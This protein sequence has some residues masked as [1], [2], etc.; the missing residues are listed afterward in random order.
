MKAPAQVIPVMAIGALL[1]LCWRGAQK[2]VAVKISKKI[3]NYQ[4]INIDKM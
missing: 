4:K 1:A 3:A 2:G